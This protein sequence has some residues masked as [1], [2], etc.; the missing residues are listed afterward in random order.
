MFVNMGFPTKRMKHNKTCPKLWLSNGYL[1][2]MY[3]HITSLPLFESPF[4]TEFSKQLGLC[5]GSWPSCRPPLVVVRTRRIR[6][7][8]LA[9]GH[10]GSALL[11]GISLDINNLDIINTSYIYI[12]IFVYVHNIYVHISTCIHM[13]ISS[14]Y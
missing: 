12:Y 11:A 5:T 13:M 6:G 3:L 1:H 2:D 8:H 9:D 7:F 4:A 14:T 10:G